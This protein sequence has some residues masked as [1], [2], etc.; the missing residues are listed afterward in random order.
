[1]SCQDCGAPCQ[2]GLGRQ[3]EIERQFAHL[4]DELASGGDTEGDDE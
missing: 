4:A 2:G 1:M 3:W